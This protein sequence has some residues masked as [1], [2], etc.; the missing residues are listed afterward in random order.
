MC[1]TRSGWSGKLNLILLSQPLRR[2]RVRQ[3]LME[4]CVWDD[5]CP[6]GDTLLF[7]FRLQ[8][9]ALLFLLASQMISGTLVCD[10]FRFKWEHLPPVFTIRLRYD[11]RR[12]LPMVADRCRSYGNEA[13]LFRL[14]RDFCIPFWL[15]RFLLALWFDIHSLDKSRI[16]YFHDRKVLCIST[17]ERRCLVILFIAIMSSRFRKESRKGIAS[18]EMHTRRNWGFKFNLS[19]RPIA[20]K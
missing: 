7:A 15:Y 12:E 14:Y 19:L 6:I 18:E 4:T 20:N 9:S 5:L 17:T 11:R 16:R 1:G 2:F 3:F 10:R 8:V 13:S